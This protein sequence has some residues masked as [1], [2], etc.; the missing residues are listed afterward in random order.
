MRTVTRIRQA[1]YGPI[2]CVWNT[3]NRAVEKD[4]LTSDI[5]LK[6]N[7]PS[8]AWKVLN[9]W[10]ENENSE[11]VKDRTKKYFETLVM[12]EGESAREYVAR[13]KGLANVVRY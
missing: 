5:V 11:Q 7:S 10:I 4:V 8:E 6:A 2:L 13:A 1:D 9:S 3:L 12:D